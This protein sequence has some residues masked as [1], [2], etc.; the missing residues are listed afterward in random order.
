MFT[1]ERRKT[2]VLLLRPRR[3]VDPRA[4]STGSLGLA[5]TMGSGI[6]E[7][8]GVG[9]VEG[10]GVR[11]GCGE[12]PVGTGV[13]VRL[14]SGVVGTGV[15]TCVGRLGAGEGRVDGGWEGRGREGGILEELRWWW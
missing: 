3:T 14:G 12:G 9:D 13:G 6:S 4:R 15:G 8:A 5:N 7:G 11:V 10:A 2:S 1:F